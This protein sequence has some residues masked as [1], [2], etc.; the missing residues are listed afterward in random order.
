M[1]ITKF[2]R[3]PN[4]DIFEGIRGLMD[5][6]SIDWLNAGIGWLNFSE[7]KYLTTET[8]ICKLQCHRMNKF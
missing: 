1:N 8:T 7:Q 3:F 5:S 4:F 6:F 2:Y